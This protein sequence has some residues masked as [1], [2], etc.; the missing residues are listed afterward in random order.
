MW[1]CIS[2]CSFKWN[3]VILF[4]NNISRLS[5]ILTWFPH[6]VN[7]FLGKISFQWQ[8]VQAREGEMS[9]FS[10]IFFCDETKW[11]H[12]GLSHRYW[13]SP[14]KAQKCLVVPSYSFLGIKPLAVLQGSLVRRGFG[15][16]VLR[17]PK[18]TGSTCSEI[19]LIP[20]MASSSP[21][22][23]PCSYRMLLKKAS[24]P[25]KMASSS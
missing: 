22:P 15:P 18:G 6:C 12:L 9:L 4:S 14:Q 21:L 16:N 20:G 1:K 11:H 25:S 19:C 10:L 5:V 23:C 8:P 2:F 17:G 13:S 3:T 7:V 24:F